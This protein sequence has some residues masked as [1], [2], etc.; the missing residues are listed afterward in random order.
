M[1]FL[2]FVIFIKTGLVLSYSF[3]A[4]IGLVE[5]ALTKL[6]D[7]RRQ[8]MSGGPWGCADSNYCYSSIGGPTM[9]DPNGSTTVDSSSSDK[10]TSLGKSS[11][12]SPGE[13]KVDMRV[14]PSP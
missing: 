11:S 14:D 10:P 6:L 8:D 5:S 2:S 7:R 4:F 13:K 12:T 1:S 3:S 9:P